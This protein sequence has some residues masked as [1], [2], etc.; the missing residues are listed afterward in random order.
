MK[1]GGRRR[2]LSGYPYNHISFNPDSWSQVA[3]RDTQVVIRT[4][5][6]PKAN[7]LD[8]LG[9]M[10]VDRLCLFWNFLQVL[11]SSS[12]D[13][14]ARRRA[15]FFSA[16]RGRSNSIACGNVVVIPFYRFQ[17]TEVLLMPLILSEWQVPLVWIFI[18]QMMFCSNKI[19]V[20]SLLPFYRQ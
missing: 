18:G 19:S 4:F 1:S 15:R 2:Y 20:L 13:I 3:G 11:L 10:L 9:M 7:E 6:Q 14:Q 12:R 5:H 17:G 16:R 8:S